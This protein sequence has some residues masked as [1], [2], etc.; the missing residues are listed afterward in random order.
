MSWAS[1]NNHSRLL[2]YSPL[3]DLEA[4]GCILSRI[5]PR[6]R[7][8]AVLRQSIKGRLQRPISAS[9]G[10]TYSKPKNLRHQ[11]GLRSRRCTSVSRFARSDGVC[12]PSGVSETVSGAKRGSRR[13]R[14]GS[15]VPR[16]SEPLE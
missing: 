10:V 3:Q 9:E 15:G 4:I 5:A 11:E 6:E 16:G 8:Q 2:D 14:D 7:Y 1:E 13:R 12:L